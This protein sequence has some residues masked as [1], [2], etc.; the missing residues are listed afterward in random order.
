MKKLEL[1][2]WLKSCSSITA[3]SSLLAT[4]LATLA[5]A[6]GDLLLFGGSDRTVSLDALLVENF[7]CLQQ[8]IY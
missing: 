3:I 6:G 4:L 7:R 8:L 1:I 5:F 2:T